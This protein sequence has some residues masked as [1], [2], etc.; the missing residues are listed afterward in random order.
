VGNEK[1]TIDLINYQ[2]GREENPIF[3]MGKGE[4]MSST[5]GSCQQGV[6]TYGKEEEE[7]PHPYED[8][9]GVAYHVN[10]HRER[11]N[12]SIVK[13]E[14]QRSILIIGGIKIFLPIMLAE[15]SAQVVGAVEAK[16]QSAKTV[17]EEKEKILNSTLAEE[18]QHTSEFL[19]QWETVICPQKINYC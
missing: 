8:S 17:I 12:N 10:E 14:D 13:E 3:L 6:V 5:K 16:I 2:E 7:R 15:A 18:E 9:C 4:E 19:T 11:L 1:R